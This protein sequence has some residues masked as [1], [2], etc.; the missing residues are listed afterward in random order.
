M[1]EKHKEFIHSFEFMR[2]GQA[3]HRGQWQSAAM[4]L[5]RLEQKAKMVEFHEF[6]RQFLGLRDRK[7]VV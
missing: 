3:I 1:E 6:D 2:L 4:I 7:S 5:R